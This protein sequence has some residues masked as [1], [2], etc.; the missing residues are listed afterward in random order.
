VTASNRVG[1]IL[2]ACQLAFAFVLITG[3]ALVARGY[4]TTLRIDPGFDTSDTLTMQVTLPRGR[5]PDAEAHA[6]FAQRAVEALVSMPGVTQAG[7]VSDLPLVGNA[8]HFA[9]RADATPGDGERMTVRPADAGF[10]NT[11]RIPVVTGRLFTAQDRG[12]AGLV[13]LVNQAAARRLGSNGAVGSR[14]VVDREPPRT[15]VGVVGE[16]KHGGLRADEGPV[17]YVPFAQKT[18]DFANW[19]GLVVRGNAGV[20]S[21]VAVRAALANVDPNQPLSAVQPMHE[22]IDAETAPYRF[23]ALIVFV[24][25]GRHC[26]WPSPASLA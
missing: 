15:I 2:L 8:L 3:S 19:M 9:V 20:P 4:V 21:A 24:L 18:F 13:A 22:Y 6:R 10:L 16:I 1:E 25:A 14:I 7:V 26:C 11:L 5:Y 23:S 12:G 17:V